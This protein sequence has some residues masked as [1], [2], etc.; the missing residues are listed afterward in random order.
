MFYWQ[1]SAIYKNFLE[2]ADIMRV[3]VGNVDLNLFLETY[4]Q[5]LC[6]SLKKFLVPL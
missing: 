2:M 3:Y 4:F 1:R 6:K 5:V